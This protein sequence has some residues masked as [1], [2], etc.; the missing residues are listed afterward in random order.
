MGECKRLKQSRRYLALNVFIA[1]FGISPTSFVFLLLFL[2][3][4]NIS[5]VIKEAGTALREL[6][7]ENPSS[8]VVSDHTK[9]FFSLLRVSIIE[10]VVCTQQPV[11]RWLYYMHIVSSFVEDNSSF[12]SHSCVMWHTLWCWYWLWT[13][14]GYGLLLLVFLCSI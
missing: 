1:R 14:D 4:Q 6:G 5:T 10:C 13:N 12:C 7:K 3:F 9:R 8:S 2:L 11:V